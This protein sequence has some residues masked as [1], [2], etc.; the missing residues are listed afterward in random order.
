MGP[1]QKG[2]PMRI[3]RPDSENRHQRYAELIDAT[4]V[5]L[6]RGRVVYGS[7]CAEAGPDASALLTADPIGEPVEPGALPLVFALKRLELFQPCWSCEGHLGVDGELWKLPR[8]WFYAGSLV[9]VKL[10]GDG[11]TK[12]QK[13]GQLRASW[14]VVLTFSD[15][16]NVENKKTTRREDV[17]GGCS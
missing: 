6:I 5:R 13:A 4:Q 11:L 14:R 17:P 10:L 7:N 1:P 16:D 3:S 15:P 8:I 2:R 12:L 9:G